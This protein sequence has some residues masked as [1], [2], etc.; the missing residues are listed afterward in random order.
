M[1]KKITS[2]E[3][4]E[5]FFA[6]FPE[7]SYKKKQTILHAGDFPQ[8]VYFL[9]KG[10]VRLFSINEDG[11]ELTLVIYKVGGI[12]PV[13]W[14]FFGKNPSIYH[15]EA[16]SPAVL[17]RAPR[18]EFIKFLTDNPDVLYEVTKGIIRR[19]VLSLRRMEYLTFGAVS[20]RLASILLI[21][22]KELGKENSRG[23]LE[24]QLPL[25]HEELSNLVG[26]ARETV[27]IEIKKFERE[28]LIVHRNRLIVIKNKKGLE[29]K[30]IL[31]A[32]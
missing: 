7:L 15:F 1:V 3:K 11:K 23:E 19:F 21:Y 27:S 22:A 9:K 17:H 12:F 30:A 14:A 25:T 24:I 16:L 6:S 28:R 31:S 8:G 2:Q 10:Y 4:L 5:N 32:S 20:A 26:V 18:E 29:D 13:V